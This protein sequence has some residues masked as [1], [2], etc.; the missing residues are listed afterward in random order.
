[1]PHLTPAESGFLPQYGA[2]L[3]LVAVSAAQ[4]AAVLEVAT[5]LIGKAER[6][7]AAA[8][9]VDTKRDVVVELRAQAQSDAAARARYTGTLASQ[10]RQIAVALTWDG[11]GTSAEFAL[12]ADGDGEVESGETAAVAVWVTQA[13][14]GAVARVQFA[15]PLT[16]A[17]AG[18]VYGL[19]VRRYE[20]GVIRAEFATDVDYRL[21]EV[22]C[23]DKPHT[24]LVIDWDDDARFGSAGDV[25]AFLPTAMFNAVSG[26]GAGRGFTF[27]AGDE[28]ILGLRRARLLGVDGNGLARV[29]M[30]EPSQPLG[31][32]LQQRRQR[33]VA[34]LADVL[35]HVAQ[36][37]EAEHGVQPLP[38]PA[39]GIEWLWLLDADPALAQ[40]KASHKPLFV[41]FEN[42]ADQRCAQLD[43]YTWN[44][45]AVIAATQA[46]VCARVAIDL[47]L[48]R[49]GQRYDVR[50]GPAFVFCAPE[51]Q[52]LLFPDRRT[53]RAVAMTRGFKTPKAMAE[54][55]AD[56]TRRLAEGRF[57]P[58]PSDRR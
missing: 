12:D 42:E 5:K 45:P 56:A 21:G 28:A 50:L 10:G 35:A 46:F 43:V 23:A 37:F 33:A 24:L 26:F 22:A 1:M 38:A 19:Q 25:F 7:A 16:I 6:N 36:E 9:T 32:Y 55:L 47:D 57:A 58:S 48:A 44:D 18:R 51:G 17:I 49:T 40:A 34:E 11:A 54:L 39:G 31:A 52:P 3:L 13:A 4:D 2:A 53:G 14:P 27:R 15:V 8:Y 20:D 30:G 41:L 29:Q